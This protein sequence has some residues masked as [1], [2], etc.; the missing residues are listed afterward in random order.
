VKVSGLGDAGDAPHQWFWDG[1]E[2]V[3][4]AKKAAAQA[5][6]LSN[7]AITLAHEYARAGKDW[8]AELRQR[9]KEVALMKELGLTAEQAV[10]ARS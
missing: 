10:P 9:A 8:Q 5:A 3:D 1:H 2:H 6:R 4:P 7:H